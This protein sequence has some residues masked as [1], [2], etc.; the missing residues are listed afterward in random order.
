MLSGNVG[1][2]QTGHTHDGESET[3]TFSG[4]SDLYVY[5]LRYSY[6]GLVLSGEYF[7]R[8]ETG[9][10]NIVVDEGNG[11]P[12]NDT[13]GLNDIE[14]SGWYVS[15]VYELNSKMRLGVRYSNLGLQ[16]IQVPLTITLQQLVMTSYCLQLM[17]VI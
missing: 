9:D 6:K 8:T 5:D 3:F 13:F 12:E 14:T 4:E 2:R 15:A 10:L 16:I 11:A 7:S 17:K 1:S